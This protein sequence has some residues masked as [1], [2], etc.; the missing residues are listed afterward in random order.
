[1]PRP[2]P[3]PTPSSSSDL[4]GKDGFL[5][6]G[7]HAPFNL[8]P[9][10]FP[11]GDR[12][13]S[14]STTSSKNGSD[15]SWRPVSPG[16]GISVE[17]SKKK[18]KSTLAEGGV[19]TRED[20]TLPPPPTRSRKII[21]MKPSEDGV[22]DDA[23]PGAFKSGTTTAGAATTAQASGGRKKSGAGSTAAGRK[24]ARK[25]AHSLIE[26]RRRSK[27]NE[28]F[29]VL[30][31]MVP[32]C[33]GQEMHKLAILQAS[34]DYLRYLEQCVSDLQLQNSTS[35]RSGP[36]PTKSA[37]ALRQAEEDLD[38]DEEMDDDPDATN[39]PQIPSAASTPATAGLEHS[40]SLVSL[41]SLSQITS[42]T[43]SASPLTFPGGRHYSMSSA[44]QASYSPYFHSNA[45]SPAFGPQLHHQP[46]HFGSG[47]FG[48]GSPALKPLDSQ[49]QLRQVAENATELL[50]GKRRPS[51]TV[52]GVAEVRE[53]KRSEHEMDQEAT[54]A[55]LM[56]NSDR[57]QWRGINGGGGAR[58]GDER[59]G[60]G[61]MS[62][63]DLLSG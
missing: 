52:A 49:Y 24:I 38:S 21:Q 51:S 1:M 7:S 59:R 15:S 19:I 20:F 22:P 62:V 60:E 18:A 54:A 45:T 14:T 57:R 16:A 41:P 29:G 10:A 4:R 46:L 61:G 28:E 42:T 50:A 33:K 40:S 12:A 48:L 58:A 6:A 34:I 5:A 13:S 39:T 9:A 36:A 3:P 17:S 47:T 35:P 2:A 30:K 44:S 27:M 63:R 56:L 32:A 53:K 26:R 43:T 37:P 23:L 25:T 31:D 55:L 11:D 8:P